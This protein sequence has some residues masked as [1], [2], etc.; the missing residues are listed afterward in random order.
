MLAS[1]LLIFM[2]EI[3]IGLLLLLGLQNN[4]VQ[5]NNDYIKSGDVRYR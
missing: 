4:D 2:L 1:V 5:D 3:I